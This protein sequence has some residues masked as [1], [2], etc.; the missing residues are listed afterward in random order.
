MELLSDALAGSGEAL[1]GTVDRDIAFDERGLPFIPAKRIRGILRESM[2]E[3][4]Y[5]GIVEAGTTEALFGVPGD[6]VSSPFILYDGKVENAETLVRFLRQAQITK[7]LAA[8]FHPRFVLE[9]FSYLRAQTSV[10]NGVAKENTLRI[11]RV[12]KKRTIFHFEAVCPLEHK[13]ALGDACKGARAFGG[14]RNRGLGRIRLQCEDGPGATAQNTERKFAASISKDDS[15]DEVYKMPVSAYALSSLIVSNGVGEHDDSGGYIPG[16]FLLGALAARYL[17][18]GGN[19]A[20]SDSFSRVFLSGETIWSNLHPALKKDALERY[21][22]APIS[23]RK[24]KNSEKYFDLACN[25]EESTAEEAHKGLG[26][27]FLARKDDRKDDKGYYEHS[28]RMSVQYHHRRAED[29][30]YGRALNP[31]AAIDGDKGGFFQFQ[32]LEG[33]QWFQGSIIGSLDDLKTI[34]SLLP[35]DGMLRLGK[36]RA[37]QYG[38][39]R[40]SF[41]SPCSLRHEDDKEWEDGGTRLFR[42]LSDAILLNDVGHPEPAPLLLAKEVA[43]VLVVPQESISVDLMRVF[44]R[45]R[46]VGGYL[47]VWNLPRVQYPALAAGSVVAMKNLSGKS[48]QIT[49]LKQVGVGLRTADGFGRLEWKNPDGMERAVEICGESRSEGYVGPVPQEAEDLVRGLLR[50]SFLKAMKKASRETASSAPELPGSFIGRL[51]AIIRAASSFEQLDGAL[52]SFKDKPAGKSLKKIA[53]ELSIDIETLAVKRED[54]NRAVDQWNPVAR[55]AT[56]RD[57]RSQSK[58]ATCDNYATY[59]NYREYATSFLSALKL[60]GRRK[61]S[62]AKEGVKP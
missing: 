30:A 55:N 38:R 36:S 53:K 5:L 11:S 47:G 37:A 57:I 20:T 4:E 49:Q 51:A 60:K 39:C 50:H 58:E 34:A 12:L 18:V 22:P 21:A 54:F 42:L 2:K 28:P 43:R 32:A 23:I 9:H 27:V 29:P 8:F 59:D 6:S 17:S 25:G 3:L 31:E 61:G 44:V 7:D 62:E 35:E 10:E 13:A 1:A 56:L 40:V 46:L 26:E 41:S 33:E 16:N 48:L 15:K 19:S 52:G 14:S 45:K 24:L